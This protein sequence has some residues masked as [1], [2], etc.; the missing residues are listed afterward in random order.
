[1]GVN[2]VQFV[3]IPVTE[4]GTPTVWGGFVKA[5]GTGD[6]ESRDLRKIQEGDYSNG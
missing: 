4:N 6:M 3:G 2:G 5:G 1:M